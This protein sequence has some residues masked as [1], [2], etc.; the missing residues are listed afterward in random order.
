MARQLERD[1]RIGELLIDF[2]NGKTRLPWGPIS[3]HTSC[4]GKL[5]SIHSCNNTCK[6]KDSQDIRPCGQNLLSSL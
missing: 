6:T 3:L 1:E 4:I 5:M 2:Q